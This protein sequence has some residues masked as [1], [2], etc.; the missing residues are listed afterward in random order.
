MAVI[1]LV[2][3]VTVLFFKLS[4]HSSTLSCLLYSIVFFLPTILFLH[5]NYVCIPLFSVAQ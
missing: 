1:L 3:F 2:C 4:H 5:R